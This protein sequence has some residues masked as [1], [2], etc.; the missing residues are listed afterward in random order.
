MKFDSCIVG[1]TMPTCKTDAEMN[2]ENKS[3]GDAI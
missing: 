2:A 1:A 3:K